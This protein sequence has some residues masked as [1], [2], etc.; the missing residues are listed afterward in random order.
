M[1]GN[2][3]C[4]MAD[5]GCERK[6][7]RLIRLLYPLSAI[8]HPIFLLLPL[9]LVSCGAFWQTD[10]NRA[11]ELARTGK[12]KDAAP[13]LETA[14]NG[15][16]FDPQIVQ[17][18]YYSWIRQGEYTK[19]REKFE[20]W[21]AANPSAGPIRLAAGRVNVLVGNY[22]A[23]LAHLNTVV[24]NP[25][26]GIAAQFE[27]AKLLEG[28]GKR[29]QANTAYQAIIQDFQS[30]R[31]RLPNDLLYA[32][33]AMWATEYFHDANDLLKIVTQDDPKNAE[34]FVFW[35]D[36]LAE[37][38]NEPEAIASYRDALKIDPSMPEAHLGLAKTTALTDP[39]TS[40]K[41]IEE[42]F[43][44][45]P[46]FVDAHLFIADGYISSTQYEKAAE[47]IA[48]ATAV[49]PNSLEA[50]SL[51]ASMGYVRNN[52]ADFDKHVARVLQIN[53]NYSTLYVTMA[54]NC[55]KL[56]LYK[57][58]AA[59][60]REGLRL[61]PRD[62]TA[63]SMLGVNLLRLGE[64]EEG[65]TTLEKSFG[66]DSFNVLTKNTLTLM[67]SFE[68]FERFDIA[69]FKVKLH[70]KESAAL[71]PYVSDLLQRA[72]NT[73]SAKYNFKPE[74]PITFEMY[75]DHA[76][77]AVRTFGLP[78]IGGILGVAFGKMFVMDSP[79]SRKPDS[80][81]WGSTLWHEFTHIITLQMTDN[82]IPRWFSEGLSVYEERRGF[83][84]WGDDLKLEYLG[85]IKAK[86]LLPVAQLDDGF[87][88]PKYE[89]Q[90]LVSYYQASM[91]CDYIDMK[92]GFP[93]ILKMLAL[94]K[95]QK[96]TVD[97]F[98]QAL[99]IT[100]ED[101]DKQFLASIDEKVRGIELEAF[102]KLL[103]S[104]DEAMEMGNL[105]MAIDIFKQAIAMYPEYTDAHNAYESLADVYLKKGDKK[106]A[107]ETLKQLMTYS[108]TSFKG[109][110]TLAGLLQE[111]G[112]IAGAS[113]AL[114]AAMYIRPMDMEGHQKLGEL[115]MNQKQYPGAAR[116][117][118]TLLA[119]NVPDRAGAYYKLAEANFGQGNRQ[120]A[121]T[122]VMKALE[123]AP[124]YEPAQELLLKIVR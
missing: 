6:F 116:E 86:K 43:Q 21:A 120:N 11:V 57:D 81:N 91:I 25:A 58:A 56:R 7:S 18:L 50:L 83:P 27:R 35:G 100:L 8:R 114:E 85:A 74:G 53:P 89:E 60:A 48:K 23:A 34:A 39:E 33:R 28:T 46:N 107:T 64:E 29:D 93:A 90:V 4:R 77:F 41:E 65:K 70:K 106:A 2:V 68:N 117:Y 3:G 79:T 5:S 31:I 99:G 82:H 72:Y 42:L 40:S 52:K 105:D 71:R 109:T 101:F 88:R 49:N 30:G 63:M 78:G 111:S 61:N 16:N 12:Y 54:D 15:G 36:L 124:S 98:K 66:G 9:L 38:Y 115:L 122:N 26:V 118:E 121:R 97:V 75:P 32:A 73:L 80:F 69:N 1:R 103:S 55:E 95:E 47:E 14:V 45:N 113:R 119:L 37:K 62:F 94:Y 92:F 110:M 51:L 96:P 67:D 13:A 59:F 17:S 104:G 24:N 84:G 123:I 19:A 22:D 44:T 112:D 102:T 76:D 108:E 20:A 10:A 87:M